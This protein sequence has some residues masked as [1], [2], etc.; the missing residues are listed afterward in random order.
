MGIAGGF[1]GGAAGAVRVV[2]GAEAVE[3]AGTEEIG[4]S[5]YYSI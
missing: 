4:Y 3:A 1:T 5:R 2:T